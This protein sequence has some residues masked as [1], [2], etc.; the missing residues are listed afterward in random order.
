MT[1]E[2]L[3]RG[4]LDARVEPGGPDEVREVGAALN[5]LAARISELLARE[6]EEVADL[7]HRLRT[8]VTALRLDV[9]SLPEAART[10]TG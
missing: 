3:G 5:R 7:S 1:A 2:R 4:D 6:R 10:G 8:P 9:E